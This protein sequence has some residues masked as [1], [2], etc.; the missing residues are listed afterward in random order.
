MRR[1]LNKVT[2]DCQL[3]RRG[4]KTVANESMNRKKSETEIRGYGEL[5]RS[6][7]G[8]QGTRLILNRG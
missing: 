2:G 3:S 7:I 1:G 8:E 6:R 5:N 4:E